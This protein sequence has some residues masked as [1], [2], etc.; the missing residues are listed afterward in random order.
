MRPALRARFQTDR[1]RRRRDALELGHEP[2][3]LVRRQVYSS[4]RRFRF[5]RICWLDFLAMRSPKNP[6]TFPH[7]P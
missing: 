3:H 7:S 4:A 1:D 5:W 6:I 2:S